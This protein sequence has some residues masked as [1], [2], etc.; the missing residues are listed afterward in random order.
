MGRKGDKE[1]VKNRIK[2]FREGKGSEQVSGGRERG[3]EDLTAINVPGKKKSV[4]RVMIRIDT[5]SCFV[6]CAI[7]CMSSVMA[8]MR[9][10]ECWARVERS[11]LVWMF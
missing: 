4:T 2:T 3:R 5:V 7:W 1:R 6:F 10:A 11:L 8:S 9:W